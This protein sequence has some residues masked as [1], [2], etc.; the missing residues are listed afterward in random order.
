MNTIP[1][2][3]FAALKFLT[4]TT[5]ALVLLLLSGCRWTGIKGNGDIVT[6]TRSVPAFTAVEA[7]GAM[8]VTWT[9]G[10]PALSITT[11][12]NLLEHL[13]TRVSKGELIIEWAKPLRGTRGI[14]VN[15]SSPSL[16][17]VQLNGAVRFNASRLSGREL[18]LEANG[19]TKVTFDGTV[20]AVSAE[21]NGASRLDA[22]SLITRA[23]ELSISGAGRAEVH[24]TEVLRVEISGAG[25]VIY[26]GEPK[27][28]TRE[29]SGAGTIRKRE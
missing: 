4:L 11:D 15:I 17:H 26:S 2:R 5:L 1:I 3:P 13:R 25:K 29:I 18:Y 20:N 8:Q 27:T 7:G 28:V 24:V 19:A 22:E 16:D 23:M 12:S 6:D 21:M 14:K 9:P 10:E